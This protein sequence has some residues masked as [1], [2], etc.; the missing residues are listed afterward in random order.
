MQPE[1]TSISCTCALS[2]C[3]SLL[4]GRWSWNRLF[5]SFWYRNRHHT[6]NQRCLQ[7]EVTRTIC[8]NSFL[9]KFTTIRPPNLWIAT[10]PGRLSHASSQGLET[11]CLS[12]RFIYN[13]WDRVPR[14]SIGP[15]PKLSKGPSACQVHQRLDTV[16]MKTL[17][18]VED[19]ALHLA[20][21][22]AP[23]AHDNLNV[24]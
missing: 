15:Y 8:R 22:P 24:P 19:L 1:G 12:T 14:G 23:V 10:R 11:D 5:F 17:W 4:A 7:V 3:P 20:V 6:V 9:N 21:N 16:H 2:R 13:L 18:V